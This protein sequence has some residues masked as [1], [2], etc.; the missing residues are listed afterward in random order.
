[1]EAPPREHDESRQRDKESGETAPEYQHLAAV[2]RGVSRHT[3]DTKWEPLP[4]TAVDRI[5]QLLND[6]ERSVVMRLQDERKRTQASTAVQMVARRLHRKLTRGQ[7]FPPST[8]SLP[9]E[10]FDFEKILDS[11]RV[12]EAQLTPMLHSIELLKAEA[13]KEEALLEADAATL[14]ALEANAKAEAS[15]RKRAERTLHDILRDDNNGPVESLV[16]S[17]GLVHHKSQQRSLDVSSRINLI[18]R[19]IC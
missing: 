7:P 11:S 18:N 15:R 19:Q 10:D 6:V 12:L 5:S 3:I 4:A 9:E 1:M 13:A 14:E 8:R 16:E 17:S 2:T